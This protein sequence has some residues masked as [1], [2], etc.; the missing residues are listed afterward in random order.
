[1]LPQP[2]ALRLLRMA[3][4]LAFLVPIAVAQSVDFVG[5]VWSGNV[6]PTSAT[7]V[8]RLNASSQRVRLV[9]SENDRLT[10]PIFSSAVN[11]AAG[12]GNTAKLTVQGLRPDTETRLEA[13]VVLTPRRVRVASETVRRSDR[14]P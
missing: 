3:M 7:V 6:T 9:V 8:A 2:W 5:G 13:V 1:M 10:P 4:A 12:T 11:T 14:R